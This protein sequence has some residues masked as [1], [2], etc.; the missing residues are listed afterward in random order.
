MVG[1]RSKYDTLKPITDNR[2][3]KRL[4]LHPVNPQIR[5][6]KQ[7]VAVF[8]SGGIVIYPTDS[9]Y[10]MG[11]YV[12]DKKAIHRL[13]HLKRHITRKVMALMFHEFSSITDFAI[14]ENAVYRYMNNRLPGPYTFILR[15]NKQGK[16]LLDV[17]R[18]EIGVRMPQHIFFET[19][20][21][22]NTTPI[23]NTAARMHPDDFYIDP[24]DIEEAFGNQVDLLVDMGPVPH[25]PTSV[26]SLV[27]GEPE[28]IRQGAGAF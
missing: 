15:A 12:G 1:T 26:I 9:G 24:D 5:L 2:I 18:E 22:I 20:H 14:V 11:C 23:L 16:K 28:L 3:V 8:E 10:S 21:T 19:L 25:N 13:Y 27:S 17:K 4:E 7:V 6:M